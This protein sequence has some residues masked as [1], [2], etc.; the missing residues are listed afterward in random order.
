MAS[1]AKIIINAVGPYRFYGEA[2]VKACLARSTHYIDVTG[3]PEFMEMI[4]L[5]YHEEALKKHVYLISACG[6]DSVPCD[7]GVIF[8]MKNFNGT[9]NSIEAYFNMIE[10]QYP[11]PIFNYATW[12]SAV[13]SLANYKKLTE[14]RSKL[15]ANRLPLRKP[16]LM[17]RKSIFK[18]EP[19]QRWYIPFPGADR[20]VMLRTQRYFYEKHNQRPIQIQCYCGFE[21]YYNAVLAVL[22][23]SIFRVLCKYQWTRTLLLNHPKLFSFGMFN[24]EGPSDE[25]Q[26]NSI[27]DICIEG[28]GWDEKPLEPTDEFKTP[29]NKKI[30]ANVGARNPAYGATSIAVVLCAVMVL[31]ESEKLPNGG[32]CYTPGVAFANTSLIAKLNKYGIKFEIRSKL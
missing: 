15:F 30:S 3:E 32:G 17:L 2:V 26:E 31:T 19:T 1:K 8:I 22:L 11:G 10:D 6:M 7:V 5:H 28:E 12:E 27:F 9:L 14:I 13:H 25:K 20:S 23:G 4:Q 21:E 29:P 18:H 16:K 24:R